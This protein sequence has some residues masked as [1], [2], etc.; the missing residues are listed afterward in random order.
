MEMTSDT[1]KTLVDIGL[2]GFSLLLWLRQ[3]KVNRQQA[4]LDA[5]QNETAAKLTQI[6]DD[7]ETRITSLESRSNWRR[8]ARKRKE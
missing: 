1:I 2:G 4:E 5:K 6:V 3:G 7:H 8:K